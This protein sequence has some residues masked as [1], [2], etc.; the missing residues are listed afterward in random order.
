MTPADML[1][2]LERW[3]ATIV[4]AEVAIAQFIAP[5]R[6]IPESAL[7]DIPYRLMDAYT[8]AVSAQVGDQDEWL[9]WFWADNEMGRKKL[10]AM[11][12]GKHRKIRTLKDLARAIADTREAP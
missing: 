1:P 8:S 10:E 6:P 12:N 5:L 4:Q 7:Y 3:K 2:H 9:S 11:I